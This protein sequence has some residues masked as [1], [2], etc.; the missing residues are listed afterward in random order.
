MDTEQIGGIMGLGFEAEVKTLLIYVFSKD[1]SI[2]VNQENIPKIVS[3]LNTVCDI[4]FKQNGGKPF[5]D[6]TKMKPKLTEELK[7]YSSV[8]S[9][10]KQIKTLVEGLTDNTRRVLLLEYINNRNEI[11]D[12]FN[13]LESILSIIQKQPEVG[14][15]QEEK[16][17]E[18]VAKEVEVGKEGTKE[19][20]E[21]VGGVGEGE[22]KKISKDLSIPQ[23]I[24][25]VQTLE[26]VEII[27][28]KNL[29]KGSVQ[30]LSPLQL[31]DKKRPTPT[32][33]IKEKVEGRKTRKSR[34][35]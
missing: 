15:T 11:D 12:V 31:E 1:S 13:K 8:N 27:D 30:E 14:S 7:N 16:A 9:A 17:G 34:H 20:E 22:E 3:L 32:P 25:D 23:Q 29:P 24:E 21:E 28:L 5:Y 18:E 2:T 4:L 35:K 10:S 26:G 6:S 33:G 19:G